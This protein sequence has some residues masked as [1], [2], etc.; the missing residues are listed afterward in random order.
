MKACKYLIVLISLPLIFM[1]YHCTESTPSTPE[2][3]ENIF[4]IVP[5]RV[6]I[7]DWRQ[8]DLDDNPLP[9]RIGETISQFIGPTQY[10]GKDA[11]LMIDSTMIG[12]TIKVD[13]TYMF[14]DADG[15]LWQHLLFEEN[16]PGSGPGWLMVYNRKIGLNKEHKAYLT[17]VQPPGSPAPITVSIRTIIKNKAILSVPYGTFNNVYPC[18]LVAS[19]VGQYMN[20]EIK[21]RQYFVPDI[22][23]IKMKMDIAEDFPGEIIGYEISELKMVR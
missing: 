12:D 18:E 15:N 9:G 20:F 14:I 17:T 21:V 3:T 1:F 7:Y 2:I 19:F 6:M 22:G 5:G 8:T 11:Y 10:Y 13:S 4:S 16:D 23:L